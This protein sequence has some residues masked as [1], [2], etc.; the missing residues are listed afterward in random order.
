MNYFL[1][2]PTEKILSRLSLDDM[3]DKQLKEEKNMSTL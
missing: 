3:R 2:K 1:W